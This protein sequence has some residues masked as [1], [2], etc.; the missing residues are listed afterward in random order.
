MR[1]SL[2]AS[3]P[4]LY[5][6]QVT[7]ALTL[8]GSGGSVTAGTPAPV[9]DNAGGV[10]NTPV[11]N[12]TVSRTMIPPGA[13]LVSPA[14]VVANSSS[15]TL[16]SPVAAPNSSIPGGTACPKDVTNHGAAS[17]AHG[18]IHLIYWGNW[19]T[20]TFNGWFT[21]MFN[22]PAFY[23]AMREYLVGPGTANDIISFPSGATGVL[24][25]PQIQTG[26]ANAIASVNEAP[27]SSDFYLVL[28]PASTVSQVDQVRN[29]SGHHGTQLIYGHTVPY[30]VVR[31]NSVAVMQQAMAHEVQEGLTDYNSSCGCSGSPL[32]C[33]CSGYTGWYDNV[34]GQEVGDLCGF[35][36]GTVAGM[37]TQKVWSQ[38]GCRC[39]DHEDLSNVDVL[40]NGYFDFTL[41][42]SQYYFIARNFNLSW[43][44]TANT[45]P[46][47]SDYNGDGRTEFA[48]YFP[49]S[50]TLETVDIFSGART[51]TS[52]SGIS[53]NSIPVTG[54]FDGDG[55]AA[56]GGSRPATTA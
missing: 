38:K 19:P 37:N 54:D 9:F 47:T 39:V 41:F 8:F 25:E 21:A 32:M 45:L 10:P 18:T 30:G 55:L 7:V 20:Q 33:G 50:A 5:V 16:G 44:F 42:R 51:D 35:I 43:S 24:T 34:S 36:G 46:I 23:N 15:N 52:F 22:T 12:T 3:T 27:S 29:W 28:F 17:I 56:R 13:T 40:G 11:I 6:V 31:P 49:N 4:R 2:K 53:S 26:I 1:E 14:T 48:T